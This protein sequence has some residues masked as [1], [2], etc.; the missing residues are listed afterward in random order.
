MILE[1]LF[2]WLAPIELQRVFQLDQMGW[3]I[4]WHWN[5]GLS[6]GKWLAVLALFFLTGYFLENYVE[7]N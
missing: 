5:L 6:V 2:R 1:P 4:V 3:E 7:A